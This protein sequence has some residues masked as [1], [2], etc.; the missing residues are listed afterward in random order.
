MRSPSTSTSVTL[1]VQSGKEVKMTSQVSAIAA[2]PETSLR[3]QGSLSQHRCIESALHTT[4]LISV[5]L[6]R[7]ASDTALIWND[8][9]SA[10][11]RDVGFG[12]VFPL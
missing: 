10:K 3:K 9:S 2:R 12:F 4:N 5:I 8:L 1:T 11:L 6:D 7:G